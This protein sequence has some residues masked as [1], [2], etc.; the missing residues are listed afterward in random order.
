VTVADRYLAIATGIYIGGAVTVLDA[1]TGQEIWKKEFPDAEATNPTTIAHGHLYFSIHNRGT[2]LYSL[3]LRNGSETFSTTLYTEWRKCLAPLVVN[4]FLYQR[5]TEDR[6]LYGFSAATAARRWHNTLIP[7][8]ISSTWGPAYA[9][10]TVFTWAHG[11]LMAFDAVT[12]EDLWIVYTNG[13]DTVGSKPI[14]VIAQKI[15]LGTDLSGLLYAIDLAEHNVRWQVDASYYNARPAVD[16]ETVY[17]FR[18]QNNTLEERNLNTGELLWSYTSDGNW[19][20]APVLT[21]KYLYASNDNGKT[22]V[23]DRESHEIVWETDHSG[24]LIVANGFLYIVDQNTHLFAFRA[25]VP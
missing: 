15:A 19:L 2:T 10:G 25:Q 5:G 1:L 22:Y 4:D 18:R 17:V 6:G 20:H 14:P 9:N 3:D 12:G 24:W 16:G 7:L 21:S 8:Q 11:N 23:F 13:N